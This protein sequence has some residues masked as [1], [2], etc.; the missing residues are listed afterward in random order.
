MSMSSRL[1]ITI[2]EVIKDI[3]E[4]EKGVFRWR[5]VSYRYKV[6]SKGYF[7]GNSKDPDNHVA[8]I[9]EAFDYNS[10][11]RLLLAVREEV[12]EAA[13][14]KLSAPFFCVNMFNYEGSEILQV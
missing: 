1:L 5:G 4:T 3:I 6:F 9:G 12:F 2:P 14:E 11:K 8:I 10:Q 13:Q 7:L